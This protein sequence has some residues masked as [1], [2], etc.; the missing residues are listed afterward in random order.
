MAVLKVSQNEVLRDIRSGMDEAAI[1][2]KY[3]LSIKGVKSLYTKLI[4]AGLLGHDLKPA[5]RKLNIVAIFGDIRAGMS[6]ADLMK[7]YELSAYMLRQVSKKLLDARGKRSAE[8]GPDTLIEEVPELLATREFVRHEVDFEVPVY[9][10]TRPE[11]H[12]M[13]RDVS[14]DGISVMGITANVGERKT[15]VILGDELGAFSSFEFEGYCRWSF[16]DVSDGTRFTGFAVDKISEKDLRELR[17]LVRL[18]TV[19]G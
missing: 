14:E 2:K 18:I 12:G 3:N 6:N 19:G 11:V 5:A 9:E 13:V 8:D 17:K 4:E 7:K 16:A 1:R 15:L 10:A